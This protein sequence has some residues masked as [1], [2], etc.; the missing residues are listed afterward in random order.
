MAIQRE[1]NMLETYCVGKGA[2]IGCG[3]RRIGNSIGVDVR[4]I[5]GKVDIIADAAKLPFPNNHLDYIVSSH[6]LEHVDRGPVMVLRE[7]VRCVRPVGVIALI[8]PDADYGIGALKLDTTTPGEHLHL[9]TPE[10]L[11]TYFAFV[12]LDVQRCERIVRA[13]ERPQP[14]IL[15]VG[16]KKQII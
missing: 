11:Q 9:F 8:V 14:T 15:C 12:G 4:P 13:P 7:W 5:L 16:I 3:A 1:I 2:N 6:C 10:T